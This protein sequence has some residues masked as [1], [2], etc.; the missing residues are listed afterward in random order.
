MVYLKKLETKRLEQNV[1]IM[2]VKVI[3][4]YAIV[5]ELEI[6]IHKERV[7]QEKEFL[8]PVT[9]REQRLPSVSP[10]HLRKCEGD[11][12]QRVKA[13]NQVKDVLV[14]EYAVFIPFAMN[15]YCVSF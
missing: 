4:K 7:E 6:R 5:T 13:T 2:E 11:I 14:P 9:I 3:E 15:M 12:E 10:S 1:S 8:Q